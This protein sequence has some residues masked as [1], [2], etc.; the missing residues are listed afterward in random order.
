MIVGVIGLTVHLIFLPITLINQFLF[1]D[2]KAIEILSK[3][4]TYISFPICILGMIQ[5][6]LPTD[7]VLNGFVNDEQLISRVD[8][9]TRI[10]SIFSF[11]KIFN[12]YLLFTITFLTGVI[13]NK[14]VKSKSI[15][16]EAIVIMLLII[17]MFMTGSRLPIGLMLFNIF[18]I[19]IYAF[20]NFSNLRKTVL[21]IA[22]LGL[23]SLL[24]LYFTTDLFN[25][26]VDATLAR[27]EKAE[28]RH[29]GESTGYTDVKLRLEDRLDIF[30]F[31]EQAGWFGYGIGMAY[32]GSQGFINKPI[33][34]YF[35]EEGERVVLELGILGGILM[36][37]MRLSLFIFAL[38]ILRWCKSIEIKLL[39]LPLVLYMLP[40]IIAIQNITFSYM[41]NF[42]YYFTFGLVI[43][44]Y[45]I[46]QK[47]LDQSA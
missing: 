27:I 24:G 6:Y 33:P 44:L 28:S 36:I 42:I 20:L 45:K 39:I 25:D 41:E 7:D 31:S 34:F 5:F 46:H 1:K 14:L 13:L 47:E 22:V 32:Q 37:L 12:A 26:P 16:L 17:S 18:A 3:I 23:T 15:L 11:V 38:Q 30:K 43:A 19:G 10:S 35:E 21:V 29:R 4:L 2:L 40:S 9:F 8:G